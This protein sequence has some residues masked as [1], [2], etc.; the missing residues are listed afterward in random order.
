MFRLLFTEPPP[1]VLSALAIAEGQ[2]WF[3]RRYDQYRAAQFLRFIG[4]LPGLTI[5]PFDASAMTRSG[6][7]AAKYAD[8]RLTRLTLTDAHGLAIMRERR[9]ATCWSTDRHL[10]VGGAALVI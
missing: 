1:L 10:G 3:L 6:A 8:Q 2:A 7:W 9:I 5:V 4:A